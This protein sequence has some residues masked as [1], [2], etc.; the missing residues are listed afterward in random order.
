MAQ[1]NLVP[2]PVAAN[3]IEVPYTEAADQQVCDIQDCVDFPVTK[4]GGFQCEE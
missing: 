1:Y 2:E 3:V 4:E